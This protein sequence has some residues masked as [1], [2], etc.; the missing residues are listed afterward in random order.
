V[1]SPAKME[2]IKVTTRTALERKML[3][4]LHESTEIE[5][6]DVEQKELGTQVSE[7]EAEREVFAMLTTVSSM[8]D[9][10]NVSLTLPSTQARVIE[11]DTLEETV[12]EI[13]ISINELKPNI[14]DVSQQLSE[15]NRDIQELRNL[16][17]S[18]Q[19]LVPLGME[20]KD[21]GEGKYFTVVAGS[22]KSE[23][24][25]RLDW[26]LKELTNNLYFFDSKPAPEDEGNSAVIVGMLQNQIE[27]ITR[28]LSSFG[29]LETIL[30]PDTMGRPI[31]VLKDTEEKILALETKIDHWEIKRVDLVAQHGEFLLAIKEQLRIESERV[32]IK[33]IMRVSKYV[34]QFWGF[35]SSSEKK[36]TTKIITSIDPDALVEFNEPDF[37]P[38]DYP[39]KLENGKY[40]GKPYEGL[41]LAYGPPEYDHDWDP[42]F[43][44]TFTFPILFGIMFADI[45]HGFLLLLLGLY[46]MR[47]KPLG[48]A[49]GGMGEEMKD[50]IQKG[51]FILAVSAVASMFFGVIFNSFA[52]LH[53]DHAPFFM[54]RDQFPYIG[55]LSL[56]SNDSNQY[57]MFGNATGSFLMLQLS[58]VIAILHISLALTLL[59]IKK[60]QQKHYKDA[61]FFPGFLLLGYL[62]AVG[63]V[64]S[65]G[66]NFLGWFNLNAP[67]AAFDIAVLPFLGYNENAF[68][69]ISSPLV[70]VVPLL[71]GF[72]GFFIY[73]LFSLNGLSIGL[74]IDGFSLGLDFL[75]SLLGNS[76]SY[77]RLFA[78]NVVH[79]ILALL[80]YNALS[81][82]LRLPF[83]HNHLELLVER[84]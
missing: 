56:F 40:T 52:G 76:I 2:V 12:T 59:I 74:D 73:E 20:I 8:I 5:I 72:L 35:I 47:L 24:V 38:E 37:T 77:A 30:P 36:K 15:L 23:R 25:E 41:V 10:I 67:P 7:S 57:E 9:A 4:A 66:I 61:I 79:S 16:H 39:T 65:Y 48:R 29:F 22:V 71:I 78:I 43:L 42:S 6:I 53:G 51:G 75:I 17:Q 83:D 60:V 44:F 70:L 21:L 62:S 3:Q 1:L 63:L 68:L 19:L 69:Q 13:K 55:N 32:E 46:G 49:P 11:K 28:V 54:Q 80:L 14:D 64:F 84:S 18:I 27:D 50:Y 31:A 33:K 26:N 58:L 82:D 81:L 45:F 34:F